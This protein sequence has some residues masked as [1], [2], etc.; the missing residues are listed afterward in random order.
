M[1]EEVKV[2][3]VQIATSDTDRLISWV[4][5]W[6]G[7]LWLAPNWSE[8]RASKQQRP[9][10]IIRSDWLVFQDCRGRA[11]PFDFYLEVPIPKRLLD[12]GA[13]SPPVVGFEIE[14]NPPIHRLQETLN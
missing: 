10:R 13:I 7:K 9:M 4:V 5:E 11:L 14:E 6:K 8:D 1:T 12:R 2:F 3:S